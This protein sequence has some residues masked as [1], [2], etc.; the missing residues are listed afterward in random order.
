MVSFSPADA[1]V[2]VVVV[3]VQRFYHFLPVRFARI[4]IHLS[5]LSMNLFIIR[6]AHHEK[7]FLSTK[8]L[9][10]HQSK[11]SCGFWK[12]SF[13]VFQ[14]KVKEPAVWP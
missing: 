2:L 9:G 3:E 14:K 12:V 13:T 1:M 10:M 6:I 8:C 4:G 5:I 7:E 11:S